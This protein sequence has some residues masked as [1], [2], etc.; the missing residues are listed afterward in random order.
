MDKAFHFPIPTIEWFALLPIL[1]VA[2]TGIC[3]FIVEMFQPK[4]ENT[5]IVGI[6]IGG[7]LVAAVALFLQ[8]SEPLYSTASDLLLRD[9]F[10]SAMQWI[11]LVA[12]GLTILFSEGY[13][14]EKRIPFGEF[15][16]LVLWSTV[17]AMIMASTTSLLVIFV[18]LEILS[19][20][21]YVMAG[22]SRSEEKSEE[23][24]LKY[25]LLGAFAS[26]F[27]LYGIA[28]VYGATGGLDL[29]FVGTA[30]AHHSETTRVLLVFG[31]AMMLIGLGFKTSLVPFHQW[32]PDVYQGA[33]T[34]VTAFMATASKIGA[35]AALWRVLAAFTVLGN[36]WVPVVSAL[37]ILTMFVGN[38]AALV[39][40]DVKRVLGYSSIANAGY[41]LIAMVAHAKDFHVGASTLVYFLLSYTFMTLGAFAVVSLGAKAGT[42]GTKLEDLNGMWKRSPF[43][44]I[45]LLIFCASLIGIPPTAGFI[46]KFLLFFDALKTGL[47]PLAL[48][49]AVN[50]VISVYYYLGIARAAFVADSEETEQKLAKPSPAATSVYALCIAG[51]FGI[52]I[53][54]APVATFLAGK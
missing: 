42:E 53:F 27:F 19:V 23:S 24:A 46:G 48:V 28:F 41:M 40:K 10:G 5:L 54:Y 4:R 26:G 15:Y 14:R 33:P 44:A 3:A 45:A 9:T 39:Q 50:S 31:L 35:F 20:S 52:A 12:C 37:A 47:W 21:L 7:L 2:L 36:Y 1:I 25:F 22:M 32:T 17:G 8:M 13:L 29:D 11:L 38:F 18:G 43:A 6:S 49:L 51:V 30:W 34:N 16:P